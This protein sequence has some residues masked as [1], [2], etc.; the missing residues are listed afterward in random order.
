MKSDATT[1]ENGI[2]PFD[3]HKEGSREDLVLPLPPIASRKLALARSQ[4]AYGPAGAQ[5]Q[6]RGTDIS[7]TVVSSTPMPTPYAS[8]WNSTRGFPENER[9]VP[10]EVGHSLP[11]PSPG[12]SSLLQG[13]L[14]LGFDS[15]VAPA[16][17]LPGREQENIGPQPNVGARG[18]GVGAS[19]VEDLPP[20]YD[21]QSRS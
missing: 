12:K 13:N 18:S 7:D 2:T 17:F 20:A 9:S 11:Y 15:E 5:S 10:L 21:R 16:Y 3:A 19:T 8:T 6:A 1:S 4:V 14:R